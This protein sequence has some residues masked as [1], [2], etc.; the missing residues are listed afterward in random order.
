MRLLIK[1]L[2][3]EGLV[4]EGG[5]SILYHFTNIDRLINILE[6]NE[7]YLTPTISSSNEKKM[8]KDKYYFLSLTRTKST[9]HGYGTKF[10]NVNSVRIKFDGSKLTSKYKIVPIDYWQYPRT[11]DLMKSNIGD[12]MED[13]L[14]SN[15]DAIP[16][17][18][19]YIISIDIF[20]GEEVDDRIIELGK[21]LGMNYPSAKDQRVSWLNYQEF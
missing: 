14:V 8:S 17:I 19:N 11:A 20:V 10:K 1:R 13:R 15:K 16:S 6:N 12:E 4:N 3:R 7:M 5:S 21:S 2:L 18:T 9:S